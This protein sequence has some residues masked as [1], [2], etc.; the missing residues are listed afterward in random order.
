MPAKK[1]KVSSSILG[2]VG[3]AV[4]GVFAGA[5]AM[6]LSDKDNREK[7]EKTVKTAVKKGKTQVSKAKKTITSAKKKVSKR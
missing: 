5:A 1:V 7:V 3:A 4:V 2:A 6:F